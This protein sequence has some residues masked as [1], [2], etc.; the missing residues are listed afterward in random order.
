MS[1]LKT[2]TFKYLM[3]AA[4]DF[5]TAWIVIQAPSKKERQTFVDRLNAKVFVIEATATYCANRAPEEHAITVRNEAIRWWSKYERV[6]GETVID[7]A[8]L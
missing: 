5:D 1:E 2:A 8:T 6:S 3:G 7:P 4:T